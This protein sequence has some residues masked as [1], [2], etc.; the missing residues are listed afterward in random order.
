M[1][2]A[3]AAAWLAAN[4]VEDTARLFAGTLRRP[5]LP[6]VLVGTTAGTGSEVSPTAVLTLDTD[7]PGLGTAGRKKSITHPS[8][9][10]R[11]AFA[12][13]RYTASLPRKPT[14]STARTPWPM[15]WKATAT[16]PAATWRPPVPRKPCP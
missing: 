11:Y 2:A 12:D 10:A 1:D 7:M 5:P 8:C 13:P 14:V 15:P 6:L 16:P 3:K 9:Y 4:R